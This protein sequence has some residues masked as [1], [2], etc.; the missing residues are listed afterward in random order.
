M[1]L[2]EIALGI[3]LEKDIQA[4]MDFKPRVPPNIKT[5][6]KEIFQPK[7]RILKDHIKAQC[8]ADE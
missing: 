2:I 7:F 8:K 1:T 5:M 3:V 4:F 6:P